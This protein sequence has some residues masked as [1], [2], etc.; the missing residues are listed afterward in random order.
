[1]WDSLKRLKDGKY[2][3]DK[4][5]GF[6]FMLLQERE[7]AD[8]KRE[9]RK[10]RV[11]FLDPQFTREFTGT[12]IFITQCSN[13]NRRIEKK[14]KNDMELAFWMSTLWFL[15]STINWVNTTLMLSSSRDWKSAYTPWILCTVIPIIFSMT[16]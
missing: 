10:V 4:I 11:L 5:I 13:V 1:M 16:D 2:L 3:N 8:A 12:D 15:E 14:S 6:Y 9:G 7:F